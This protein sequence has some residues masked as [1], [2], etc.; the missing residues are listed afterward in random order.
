ML[1]LENTKE[2]KEIGLNWH[3]VIVML[4][5]YHYLSPT[6]TSEEVLTQ[7]Y[8]AYYSHEPA[9]GVVESALTALKASKEIEL[10]LWASRWLLVGAKRPA[11]P[12]AQAA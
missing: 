4:R 12:V 10:P 9:D 1:E 8:M 5:L 11:K 2:L 6:A 3:S 7:C